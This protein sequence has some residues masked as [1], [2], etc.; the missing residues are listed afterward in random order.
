MSVYIVFMYKLTL[1]NGLLVLGSSAA[2][3]YRN[4]DISEIAINLYFYFKYE[5]IVLLMAV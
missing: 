3:L 5:K 4:E 1:R 2:S